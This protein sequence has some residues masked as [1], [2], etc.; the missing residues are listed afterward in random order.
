[1]SNQDEINEKLYKVRII[2]LLAVFTC[3]PPLGIGLCNYYLTHE[4][5]WLFAISIAIFNFLI[6]N[7]FAYIRK[8]DAI[9]QKMENE[10]GEL[11]RY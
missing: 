7:L 5:I 6:L 11:K 1:M 3:V 2:Q 8:R 4:K 9:K 10:N